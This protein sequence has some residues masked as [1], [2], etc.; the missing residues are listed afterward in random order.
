MATTNFVTGT[1]IQADWLN[2]VDAVVYEKINTTTVNV[3]T[4]ASAGTANST[5]VGTGSTVVTNTGGTAL[6]RS[7]YASGT[8]SL[9]IQTCDTSGTYGAT[10]T[11]AISI[12]ETSRATS[13][14]GIAIGLSN[15]GA[16]GI[17]IGTS[18]SSSSSNGG[19]AIGLE[20]V[21]TTGTSSSSVALG[22]RA[23]SS[24]GNLAFAAGYFAAAG[25]AQYEMTVL[26][27]N[28]T[29]GGG[30]VIM[31]SDGSG[32]QD[33]SN[34]LNLPTNGDTRVIR[35]MLIG[36]QAS[37]ANVACYSI[38]A[39]VVNQAGTVTAPTATITAIGTPSIA[40]TYTAP[41]LTADNTNKCL[42]VTSGTSTAAAIRWV[43]VLESVKVRGA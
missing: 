42:R 36:R 31:V 25:D 18:N 35:G 5:A 2:D 22:Y 41:I 3:G 37:S 11:N 30:V 39:I 20:N 15:L 28:T 8:D 19:V 1:V 32:T 12:G 7:A 16:G 34:S 13:A 14:N 43:C 40:A 38:E 33:T 27:A 29:A 21:T 10:N 17:A 26:R 23:N 24:N 6:G 9:A 4:S